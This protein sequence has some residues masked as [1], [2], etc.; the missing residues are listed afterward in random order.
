MLAPDAF[1]LSQRLGWPHAVSEWELM[2]QVGELYILGN[3]QRLWAT[4]LITK[5]TDAW[6]NIGMVLVDP[7]FR[8]KGTGSLITKLSMVEALASDSVISLTS[9]LVAERVYRNLDFIEVA[10][11]ADL[12]RS[13]ISATGSKT[14]PAKCRRAQDGDLGRIVQLEGSV[15]GLDRSEILSRWIAFAHLTVVFEDNSGIGGYACLIQRGTGNDRY[16]IIGPLVA[17]D[18]EVA[19]SIV[20]Y[21]SAAYTQKIEVFV[22]WPRDGGPH[23]KSKTDLIDFLRSLGFADKQVLPIMTW[24]GHLFPAYQARENWCPVSL[25]LG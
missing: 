1:A 20:E 14:L 22:I 5:V 19:T 24:Q 17:R 3:K 12:Q 16:G 23:E 21:I 8:K 7:N 2:E 25:A 9:S 13:P 11:M 18:L 4:S 6:F 15:L 10:S